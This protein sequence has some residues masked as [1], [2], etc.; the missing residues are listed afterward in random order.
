MVLF[1]NF[2]GVNTQATGMTAQES[3]LARSGQQYSVMQHFCC[4]AKIDVNNPEAYIT[5]NVVT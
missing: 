3:E 4:I 1:A 2:H 5:V